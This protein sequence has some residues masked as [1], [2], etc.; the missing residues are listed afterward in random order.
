M[1]ALD[2]VPRAAHDRAEAGAGQEERAGE[3]Q[4]HAEDRR[5][6]RAEPERDERLERVSERAAVT[7]AERQHQPGERDAE[8]EPEGPDV[9]QF[10]LRH[11]QGAERHEHQR[12]D[13]RGSPHGRLHEVADRP[14]AEA[15]PEHGREEDA[16]R[17]ERQ[18]D[19]LGIVMVG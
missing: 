6:G 13:V 1:R 5:A 18:P 10:A 8:A 16:D 19:Q 2:G 4:Q 11:H 12:R 14:A 3:R 9:D 17:A 7:G 15:E